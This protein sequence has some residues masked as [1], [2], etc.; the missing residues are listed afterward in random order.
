M[1]IND[2]FRKR[3]LERLK[4]DLKMLRDEMTYS[5]YL[6]AECSNET[7]RG[8]SQRISEYRIWS[9]GSAELLRRWYK[10]DGQSGSDREVD[11]QQYFWASCPLT[12]RMLH[13]GVPGLICSK[14]PRILFG[15][16][17][18]NAV[19]VY[20]SDGAKSVK[21][22]K[23]A[24][25]FLTNLI[26]ITAFNDKLTEAATCE[27][28]SGHC[29]FKFS[30]DLTLS[31]YPII[32]T[33]DVTNTEVV[34]KRG[35]TTAIIFKKWYEQ[36][37]KDKYRLDEI[38]SS[39]ELR[40]A[41]ITYRLVKIESKKEVLKPLGSI[42]ETQELA[43]AE[44]MDENGTIT[45]KGLYGMLAFEKPNKMPSLEFPHCNYGASDFEG[46]LDSFDSLDESYSA[47]IN[48]IRDNR[49]LRFWDISLCRFENGIYITPDDGYTRNFIKGESPSGD[50]DKKSEIISAADK[51]ELHKQKYLTALCLAINKAG[52]S[53][54]ALGVTGLESINS[55]SESQQE[56]NKVTLETRAAKLK[57]WKP[58]LEKI[59]LQLLAY[60]SWLVK[61][62]GVKQTAF[63]FVDVDFNNT[64][65][66]VDFGDYISENVQKRTEIW[67]V[68]KT[69]GIS[70]VETAVREIH[71]DWDEN[72][73][74][75]ETNRIYFENGTAADNPD[76]LPK[77]DGVTATGGGGGNDNN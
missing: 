1:F 23:D 67:G 51:T 68:A 22:S 47:I 60:N 57:L 63:N 55:S 8:F 27:S 25:E 77:L 73:I 39:N 69:S 15:G 71:S 37:N 6:C 66:N 10:G 12:F 21:G 50:N 9:E 54:F 34:K 28:W 17:I 49:T 44:G 11:K 48:E 36:P 41:T 58:F 70:S 42:P 30:H 56:R 3:R 16:G 31:D 2:F 4:G 74:A 76:N 18:K 65:V 40:E 45:F 20:N 19:T 38:Y 7:A 61:A 53:P 72:Q 29:F 32:E 43:E 52:L 62:Q 5:P 59:F 33:S 14:M 13:C 35:I 75:D 24:S 64:S 46:A 26:N